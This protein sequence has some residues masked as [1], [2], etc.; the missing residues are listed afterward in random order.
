MSVTLETQAIEQ[1]LPRLGATAR[2]QA[3]IGAAVVSVDANYPR[4]IARSDPSLRA[5]LNAGNESP[6]DD[7]HLSVVA[8]TTG[9]P[10]ESPRPVS[11]PTVRRQF[12]STV[13]ELP[14]PDPQPSCRDRRSGR[15]AQSVI[16]TSCSPLLTRGNTVE[17]GGIEPPSISRWTNPLRPFPASGL[18]LPHRRVGWWPGGHRTPGLSLESAVFP[19][20]SGLSHRHP[21][22]LLPGCGGPA[23]C[24]ISAHDDSSLT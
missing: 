23:P 18:S 7:T 1:G 8:T 15:S 14:R 22:L 19:A 16:T 9:R 24:G 5:S 4:S 20:V 11:S 17:L 13:A 3:L 12:R 10:S 6:D 2:L 21:P